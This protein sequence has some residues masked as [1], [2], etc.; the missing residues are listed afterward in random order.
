[1]TELVKILEVAQEHYQASNANF[2]MMI[3]CENEN[4]KEMAQIFWAATEKH[5]GRCRGLLDAYAILTG[6]KLYE[7]DIMNELEN[8]LVTA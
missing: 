3:K 7:W 8:L 1:M 2:D 6:T 4:D 5:T